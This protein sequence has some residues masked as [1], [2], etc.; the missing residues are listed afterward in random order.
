MRF[1]RT[2]PTPPRQRGYALV[3]VMVFCGLAL[4]VLAGAMEWT[5]SNSRL[6]DR[7]NQTYETLYAAEAATEK[8][9]SRI[10]RDFKR[11][12]EGYV[13]SHLDDYRQLLPTQD[14][15]PVWKQYD[16]G[17][18]EGQLGRITVENL[19]SWG[20][21]PLQS[22]YAGLYGM[23]AT[24][25]VQCNARRNDAMHDITQCVQQ[26]VQVATIPIFQFAIFYGLDM[27]ISCGQPFNV[28][29]RVHSNG[30]LWVCPDNALTFWTDVTAV[31]NIKFGRGPGDSRGAPSGTVTYKAEHDSKVASMNLP[32]GTNNTPEAVRAILEVP[33][34]GEDPR[35]AMGQQRMYNK[36]DLIIK[37]EDALVTTIGGYTSNRVGGVWQITTNYITTTNIIV[38]AT[39][40]RADNFSKAVSNV[41][42]SSFVKVAASSSATNSF[43]DW[44]E[45][46]QVLPID[47]DVGRM[48]TNTALTA[49]L[50]ETVNLI[51]V[52][53][54]RTYSIN[55]STQLGAVRV[56]NGATLP[57]GGLTVATAKPLYVQGH[58]NAP[59]G[60]LGT[61]NTLNT[62]PAALMADA[63]TMLSVAWNDAN[64]TK[65]LATVP[66]RQALDTTVNAAIIAGI[67]PTTNWNVYSGGAEN[68]PRFLED[69]NPSTGK[70]IFTYNGSMVVLFPSRYATAP[71][72]MANVYDPPARNWAFDLNFLDA[73][74]LPPGTPAVSTLIRG[75]WQ[76]ASPK[77]PST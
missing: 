32:I 61:T 27:E 58:Y 40:G 19:A 35:S 39:S 66:G 41:V 25:R 6:T 7:N 47:I 50:G 73:K 22:Q 26:D 17:N 9:I 34:V 46:K 59:S 16:F 2:N 65:T 33:P 70:K 76:I 68:F 38:S 55:P 63:V 20:Y 72:G 71:W 5:S 23:A 14:E 37:V 8:V 53:D 18:A 3:M 42:L 15:D 4:M 60:S 10:T 62:K 1:D 36:A 31:G 51:Y 75:T 13:Y 49:A 69:W 43:K 45:G 54:A 77:R 11:A 67:V 12:D 28:T 44:R 57:D 52:N 64:S 74:K 21:T 29:G 30:N 24:Y 56:Q 48:R